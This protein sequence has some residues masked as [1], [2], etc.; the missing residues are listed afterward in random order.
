MKIIAINDIMNLMYQLIFLISAI[1]IIYYDLSCVQYANSHNFFSTGIYNAKAHDHYVI[2]LAVSTLLF[3]A[4]GILLYLNYKK[5]KYIRCII[6]PL[7]I[8]VAYMYIVTVLIWNLA[9]I[10]MLILITLGGFQFIIAAL[11]AACGFGLNLD[12]EDRK[13]RNK[14]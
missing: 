9:G 5:I 4:Y 6:F 10:L 3:A 8:I 11:I 1:A 13:K 12:L 2:N 14:R 7:G